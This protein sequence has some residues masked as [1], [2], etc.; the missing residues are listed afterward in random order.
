MKKQLILALVLIGLGSGLVQAQGRYDE[1]RSDDR[2]Y[3]R[4][5]AGR[6]N[7]GRGDR[8]SY[9][10]DPV[11]STIETL[12]AIEARAR[13]DRHEE[14][15]IRRAVKELSEF[16]RRRQRGQFDR[17]SLN[18]ALHHLRDLAQADQ[19]KPRD[20]RIIAAHLNELYRLREGGNFY[21]DRRY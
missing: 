4:G 9:R 19:L 6:G 1:H 15:H 5:Y 14:N 8:E 12:Y 3:G 10:R 17:D 16:D 21:G 2:G 13:V 11:R 20:R 18:D 7:Q